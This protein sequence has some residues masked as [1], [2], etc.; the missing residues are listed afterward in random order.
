M[1][2]RTICRLAEI[3]LGSVLEDMGYYNTRVVDSEPG[4]LSTILSKQACSEN[5]RALL[6]GGSVSGIRRVDD[7]V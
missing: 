5:K 2:K 6:C 3:D 7:K 1:L 4:K